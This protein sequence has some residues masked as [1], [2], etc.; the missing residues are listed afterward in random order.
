MQQSLITDLSEDQQYSLLFDPECYHRTDQNFGSFSLLMLRPGQK[1]WHKDGEQ[2]QFSFP[3]RDL[4][5]QLPEFIDRAV[6]ENKNLFISQSSFKNFNRKRSSFLSSGCLFVDLDIYTALSSRGMTK[7]QII[8]QVYQCCESFDIPIP[9]MVIDSGGG[10]Y[11]KWFIQHVGDYAL[12]FWEVVQDKLC[13]VFESLGADNNARDISRVLRVVGSENLKYK[14]S[15][16]CEILEVQWDGFEVSR[17]ELRDFQC[18]LPYSL[19]DAQDFKLRMSEQST[20][21]RKNGRTIRREKSQ[22][23]LI[24]E[25]MKELDMNGHM[26]GMTPAKLHSYIKDTRMM[27]R[28][29]MPACEKFLNL[30]FKQEKRYQKQGELFGK[31]GDSTERKVGQL[32][33]AKRRFNLK[34]RNWQSYQDLLTLAEYRY[35]SQGVEDGLRDAFFYISCN[36]YALSEWKQKSLREIHSEWNSIAELLVPHWNKEK[37]QASLHAVTQRL[38]ETVN[39]TSW[40]G[41]SARGKK[42]ADGGYGIPLYTFSDQKLHDTLQITQD[43]LQLFNPDGTPLIREILGENERD[44]RDPERKERMAQEH[45]DRDTTR[46]RGNGGV[47]RSTYE[48]KRV[49][50]VN[51]LT[52]SVQQML[53]KGMKGKDIA[54]KLNI[55]PARVSQL[56]KLNGCCN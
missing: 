2:K 35:G 5:E 48:S 47:D 17:H 4:P 12:S 40:V 15:P 13:T 52:E 23:E 53:S 38:S 43:E 33:S 21:Y 22:R 36:Q 34:R 8:N 16:K 54:A 1:M 9:S 28:F 29:S 46:R 7:A 32:V 26:I 49:D 42:R 56:K 27:S 20:E 25:C 10:L 30:W 44:R 41:T 11:L 55:T 6:K 19:Q 3:L 14:E 37:I 24:L 50:H 39:D 31:S 18:L 51:E 45:R